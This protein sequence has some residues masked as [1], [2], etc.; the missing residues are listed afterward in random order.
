ML[1]VFGP[2]L[3]DHVAPEKAAAALEGIKRKVLFTAHA[4]GLDAVADLVLPTALPAEKKGSFT[5]VDGI[6]LSFECAVAPPR[7]SLPESEILA[8][9][10][11]GLGVT[12][13]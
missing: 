11:A 7:A 2:H 10:A 1:L 9:L 3:L 8:R 12:L 5:N 6:R 13:G 4:S